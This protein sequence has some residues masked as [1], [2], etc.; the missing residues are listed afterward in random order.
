MH[1]GTAPCPGLYQYSVL[2]VLWFQSESLV[3]EQLSAHGERSCEK[4]ESVIVLAGQSQNLQWA[5]HTQ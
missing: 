2:L 3:R 4:S 5:E 1:A